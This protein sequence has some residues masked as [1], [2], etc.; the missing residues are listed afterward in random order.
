[1][2][3]VNPRNLANLFFSGKF[4]ENLENV[5]IKKKSRKTSVAH[6]VKK[7]KNQEKVIH[8]EKS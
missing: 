6:D 1:M 4:K 3:R 2:F 8:I 7:M 5:N